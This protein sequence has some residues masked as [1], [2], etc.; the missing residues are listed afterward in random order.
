MTN[1]PIHI[2]NLIHGETYVAFLKKKAQLWHHV[3]TLSDLQNSVTE[4][5]CNIPCMT[6]K[7]MCECV[8][9]SA[10]LYLMSDL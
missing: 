6:F 5:K 8:Y 1:F 3:P 4:T 7:P 2:L 10:P 9:K